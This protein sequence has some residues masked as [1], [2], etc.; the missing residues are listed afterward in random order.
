MPTEQ[1]SYGER[2][3]AQLP[4]SLHSHAR[5]DRTRRS[6]AAGVEPAA[7]Q[8]VSVDK[9]GENFPSDNTAPDNGELHTTSLKQCDA[10]RQ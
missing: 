9:P 8:Q 6:A 1:L 3:E 10:L 7:E 2:T 5:A 4:L